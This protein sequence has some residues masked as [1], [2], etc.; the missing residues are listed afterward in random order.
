M[1]RGH[2]IDIEGALILEFQHDLGESLGRNID[3]EVSRR[4]L[5]ILAIDAFERTSAEEHGARTRL[6]R[7]GRLLPKMQRRTGKPQR[8]GCPA[9]ATLTRRSICTT[10]ARTEFARAKG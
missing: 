8:V 3:A 9:N 1:S 2:E 10:P 6:A 4:N 7:D 5:V